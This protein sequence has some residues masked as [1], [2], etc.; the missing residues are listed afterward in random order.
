MK[1]SFEGHVENIEGPFP[2][3]VFA[4]LSPGQELPFYNVGGPGSVNYEKA[5]LVWA[6]NIFKIGVTKGGTGTSRQLQLYTFDGSGIV[7]N[8]NGRTNVAGAAGGVWGL[9]HAND[10]FGLFFNGRVGAETVPSVSLGNDSFG[11]QFGGGAGVN[12]VMARISAALNQSSTAGF[13]CLDLVVTGTGG[14]G[15]QRLI[16]AAYGG[17]TRFY[18]DKN[19]TVVTGGGA[20]YKPVPAAK[21]A[22][23]TVTSDDR[24]VVFDTAAAART[25][26]LPAAASVPGME[27]C[28]RAKGANLV[29]LDPNAAELI[30]G[31]ATLNVAANTSIWIQS[32]GTGWV[33]MGVM[34]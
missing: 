8:D 25:C 31:A 30:E 18:V 19:G 20:A 12:Q 5:A 22:T 3:Y 28:V 33:K 15:N 26:N 14:S 29:T 1:A 16:S 13:T 21:T 9:T 23:Y 10:G 32:D 4:S 27:L 34:S 6:S 7:F 11:T 17:T 24:F 2:R